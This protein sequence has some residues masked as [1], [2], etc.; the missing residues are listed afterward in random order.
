LMLEGDD[1]YVVHFFC[2]VVL[3]FASFDL[4]Y[5]VLR[6]T[7]S[8]CTTQTR[9]EGL[10]RPCEPSAI[11]EAWYCS[12]A[13]TCR[14][15]SNP[16]QY[17]GADFDRIHERSVITLQP[18]PGRQHQPLKRH[19]QF[20]PP[21]PIG[22]PLGNHDRAIVR[23]QHTRRFLQ[24]CLPACLRLW[25]NRVPVLVPIEAVPFHAGGLENVS[26]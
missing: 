2:R 14:P 19:A 9:G 12:T 20:K 26:N 5:L 17:T 11:R 24:L 3:S 8:S 10:V 15:Q 6:S 23:V 22:K 16:K 7:T 18:T 21:W 13:H 4:R 1:Q 25:F